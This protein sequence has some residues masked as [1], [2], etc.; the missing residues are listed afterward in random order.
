[1]A[2]AQGQATGYTATARD[3]WQIDGWAPNSVW[4]WTPDWRALAPFACGQPSG[5]RPEW[6]VMDERDVCAECAAAA[7]VAVRATLARLDAW[8]RGE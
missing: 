4:H 7:R 1:M 3:A 2:D 5:G 6:G 8:R